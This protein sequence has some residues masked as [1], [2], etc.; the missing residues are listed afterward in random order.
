MSQPS[1]LPRASVTVKVPKSASAVWIVPSNVTAEKF[2]IVGSVF[3]NVPPVIAVELAKDEVANA[4]TTNPIATIRKASSLNLFIKNIPPK[5]ICVFASEE[6]R[7][8][9][10]KVCFILHSS[11][12]QPP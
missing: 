5:Q 6:F 8:P 2:P 3:C 12:A 7:I 11:A 9:Q 10:K 1:P 4:P